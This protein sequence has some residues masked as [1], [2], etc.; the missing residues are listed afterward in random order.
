MGLQPTDLIRGGGRVRWGA[1]H[2]LLGPPHPPAGGGRGVKG[3]ASEF[4]SLTDADI[5]R[6]IAEDP[7]LPPP[8]GS[9]APLSDMRDIRRKVVL[10]Q[11]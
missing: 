10:T 7:E 8:T 1:A 6:M 3:A 9:L 2:R 4:D 11:A 5:D